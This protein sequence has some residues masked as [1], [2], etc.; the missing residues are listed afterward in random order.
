MI[1]TLDINAKS[2][3]TKRLLK[4]LSVKSIKDVFELGDYKERQA[5]LINFVVSKNTEKIIYEKLFDNFSL[6]KQHIY[7]YEAKGTFPNDWLEKHPNIIS[8]SK[9]TTSHNIYNLIYVANY[10]YFNITKSIAEEIQFQLPVQIHRKGTKFI[11]H[12]NI[13]ERDLSSLVKD[14]LLKTSKDLNDDII[15]D[16]IIKSMPLTANLVKTDLNKG[17]KKI[18]HDNE[19]DACKVKYKK[20]NS[21]SSEVMDEDFL[22]KAK[23]PETYNEL[24]KAPLNQTTFRIL[25]KT[26]LVQ[27]FVV[28]PTRGTFSFT[29]FPQNHNGINDLIDIILNHN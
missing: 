13:L 29:I 8:I 14:K 21:T 2:E 20:A 22:L 1:E 10:K 24:I 15:I 17:I 27:Y 19:V 16:D 3:V 4:S 12:I 28:E 5:E 23:Y 6:L 26:N 25:E 11:L 9:N 18:W 7:V